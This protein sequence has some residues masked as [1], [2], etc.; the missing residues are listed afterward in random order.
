MKVRA[1]PLWKKLVLMG[2]SLV[3]CLPIGGELALAVGSELQPV[4]LSND[5][6]DVSVNK[7]NGRFS[8]K[9]KLGAPLKTGDDNKSLLFQ[10]KL[11]DTSFTTFRINGKDYIYGNGYGYLGSNGYFTYSPETQGTI[12]QSVWHVDGLEI[13]QTL[14]LVDDP[15]NPNAG[16][17]K[18]SYKVINKSAQTQQVGSRILL[19][20]MLGPEDAA[21][22][23]MAN[24]NSY[25]RTETKL[26]GPLPYYWRATDN[27]LNPKVLSYGFLQGWGNTSPNWMIIAHWNGI[28]ETKWDYTV[29]PGLDFTNKQN[30]YGTADSAVAMYWDPTALAPGQETVYETYYGLGSFFT[31]EKEASYGVQIGAPKQLSL[32]SSRTGYNEDTFE[33][34]V[35]IDNTLDRSVDQTDVQAVLGLP[36]DLELVA[37]ERATKAVGSMPAGQTRTVAWKV[38]PKPQKSYKAAQ[39]QV[40]VKAAGGAENVQASYVVLP[41]LSGQLPQIQLLEALP[42]NLYTKDTNPSVVLQGKGFEVLKGAADWQIQ[43]IRERDG[44]AVA[45]PSA[46]VNVVDD[47]QISLQLSPGIWTTL[48][49][50]PGTYKVRILGGARGNFEQKIQLTNDAKYKTRDYGL[51]LVVGEQMSSGGDETYKLVP[52]ENETKLAEL[53]R[54]YASSDKELLLEFRGP[55][56]SLS[57]D[58][59]YFEMG[60]GTTINSVIRH[61]TSK[62]L[63]N[64]FG[65]STQKMVIRKAEQDL[66]HEGDYIELKGN[67]VLTIPGFPFSFGPF[68]IEM[69]DGTHYALEADEDA[70]DAPIEIQWEVLKGLSIVQ[71]MSF[72]QVEIKNAVIGNESVSFGGSVSLNFNPGQKKEKEGEDNGN[73]NGQPPPSNNGGQAGDDSERDQSDDNLQ[74]GIAV[75]EARFG[76]RQETSM[77][78]KAGTFGFIGLRAEGEA[79]LPEGMIPGLDFGASGRVALDT[80][81]KKFEIE[82]HVQF[83]VVEVDGL[84]TLRFTDIGVPIPDN[85]VFV[86]G[87]EPGIP[88][89]PIAPVAYITK[90]GG[91]FRNLYDSLMG[92]FNILPPL[93]LLIVG[94]LSV[95]KV[96]TADNVTLGL[97]ARGI[98]FSG[99]FEI[100]KFPILKEVYG[101]IDFQDSLSNFGVELKAGARLEVFDAIIGE[102]H[103]V[104][105]YDSSRH[106]LL[107]PVYLA[108]GGELTLR[109]P[110]AVP[111]LGGKEIA[112]ASGEISSEKVWGKVRIIGIPFGYQYVWGNKLPK[113]A[114]VRMSADMLPEPEGLS[115][116]HF[117]DDAGQASSL[118]FGTNIKR[119]T[120]SSLQAAELKSER[121]SI[122]SASQT[123]PIPVS[124]DQEIALFDLT[125]TGDTLPNLQVKAPDGTD[126]PLILDSNYMTQ[127]IPSEDSQSGLPEKHVYISVPKPQGGSIAG[128]WQVISDQPL[129]WALMDVTVPAS[130]T[131]L[132]AINAAD[133]NSVHVSWEG[134]HVSDE[135]VSLFL[136]S[137]NTDDPGRLLMKDVPAAN[138]QADVTLPEM[139][140][141][142]EY[143]IKAVLSREDTNMDSRYSTASIHYV[144]HDQPDRPSNVRLVPAG[145]GFLQVN[146]ETP[147]AVDGYTLQLLDEQGGPI[148][149]L[150]TIDLAGDKLTSTVGGMIQ[151]ASGAK[152]GL[153][154][155]ASYKVSIGSYKQVNGGKVYSAPT[156]SAPVYV[157]VPA[158]ASI[159]LTPLQLNHQPIT[160]RFGDASQETY[161]TKESS[162]SLAFHA[163][164]AV[165]TV[166]RVNDKEIGTLEGSDWQREIELQEGTN[167]IAL[168]SKNQAGDTTQSGIRIMA[169][170]VPPDLKVERLGAV[171]VNGTVMVKG[172]AEPG[173]RLT[174]EGQPIAVEADGSFE[175]AL[176]LDGKL[177]KTVVVTATDDAGNQTMYETEMGNTE[178]DGLVSVE[179]SAAASGDPGALA[180]ADPETE[181]NLAAGSKQVL[182]LVATDAKGV[183][184]LVNPE[185]VKWEI[186]HGDTQGSVS[187]NGE[188]SANYEGD[189]VVKASYSVSED[190]AFEDTLIVKVTGDPPNQPDT[191]YEDWYVPPPV[192][193]NQ[194]SSPSLSATDRD[195]LIDH[196][197]LN[198][199]KQLIEREQGAKYVGSVTVKPNHETILPIGNRAALRIPAQDLP[200]EA[201]IAAGVMT[202]P[203]AFESNG[204]QVI[205]DLYELKWDNPLTLG[206]PAE[207]TIRFNLEEIPDPNRAAIYWYNEVAHR[208]EYIGG[209]FNP[210]AGTMT[211]ALP[212]FSKYA[213]LVNT[214]LPD[215]EDMHSR[216]SK[217]YVYQLA[218][219]GAIN[220]SE[221]E[222]IPVFEPERLITRQEFAKIAVGAREG[223]PASD[224]A[225][226]AGMLE[227]FAD[228]NT[229][230]LWAEPY[231]VSALAKQWLGGSSQADGLYLQPAAA[232]TRAEA[233]AIIGRMLASSPGTISAAVDVNFKD[234]AT[235]PD[236]AMA[237]VPR[238]TQSGILSGYPDGTLRPDAYITREEAAAMISRMLTVLSH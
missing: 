56:R 170:T 57:G 62:E 221:R 125:Y 38:K 207:L 59:T 31:S 102:V 126:Y 127:E 74:L 190:Y 1:V 49:E 177:M 162:F 229:V 83:Q 199:L 37:E 28:S 179:I 99:E 184:T 148:P 154:P 21:P 134:D 19:D 50:E 153:V 30:Q 55:I 98:E 182:E 155:G 76:M 209:T 67:G 237:Y 4:K 189:I 173:S 121:V 94:G 140:A 225:E 215:F 64:I 20:T 145:N 70:G 77:F 200:R 101:S 222:G 191:S 236:W 204:I 41:A 158:P 228:H 69:V 95:A 128:N 32:N 176:P 169:D 210:V 3:L 111:I 164:Q 152:A 72:F 71:H 141:S 197:L 135:K 106:G 42:K 81:D 202:D 75:D 25:I 147:Q 183:K 220:G 79:G 104:F 198:L 17:M 29:N 212:H 78:G 23:S 226:G 45:V 85:F 112:H 219:L 36:A 159:E 103:V 120:S 88:L 235:I 86:V 33:I 227:R 206:Q 214:A 87:G 44:K 13:T 174:I 68:Q 186:L 63:S 166:L 213:L 161:V 8:V 124:A 117:I 142:G 90:G 146:W 97:S 188:L 66:S 27:P 180:A 43:V 46:D 196:T 193:D 238:L 84:L 130:L 156:I 34:R 16:N 185:L 163:D 107:G 149:G 122:L 11:P 15:T 113:L 47:K 53:K 54:Q 224:A 205:G 175:H 171:S 18:V 178:L 160:N 231:I 58:N 110:R 218:S 100:V 65:A 192:T 116:Q 216:W 39:Y 40:I 93:K 119:V 109:I 2:C 131:D 123:Y 217:D 201:N 6:M 203:N 51:L 9:T 73:N 167:Q 132:Q 60:P 208:W 91:G 168:F 129:S 143:Y 151:D 138:G 22:I 194:E 92:N 96:V 211:A 105:G 187:D 150:G 61:D 5:F 52:V 172:A 234:A 24:G 26:E 165:S 223:G 139:T 136:S 80:F 108:G 157:P 48:A 115:E 137:N 118:T 230:S 10:D 12:N 181:L 195:A 82:G 232:I 233:M 7:Q 114:S 133:A 35:D 14:T 89:I 144:N